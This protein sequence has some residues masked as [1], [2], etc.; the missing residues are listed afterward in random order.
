MTRLPQLPSD[1]HGLTTLGEI[2]ARL[3][4]SETTTPKDTEGLLSR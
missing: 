3:I 1:V 4:G 2:A